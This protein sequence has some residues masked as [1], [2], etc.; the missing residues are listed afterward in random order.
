M[1]ASCGWSGR[2]SC[3]AFLILSLAAAAPATAEWRRLDSPNFVVVGDVGAGTLRD[4]ASRFEGFR[5][6][7]A[8]VLSDRVT[9]T[10]VPTVVVV[11]PSDRGFTPFKPKYQG[12][13]IEVSGL[14]VGGQDVNYIAILTDSGE[15]GMRVVFH[16]YAHLIIS[17]V[18]RNVPSWLNE[19]LAEYYST[20]EP[21]RDG[22]E[23]LL[24]RSIAGHLLR[25]RETRLLPLKELLAV[26]N[27]SPLY[28]EGDRR[29]VFYAQSWALT[30]MLLLGEPPRT[31]QL[32]QYL[33]R[34]GQGVPADDAW[35]Q[36]FGADPI[37]RDLR[38]YVDR[39]AFSAYQYKFPEKVDG[40]DVQPVTLSPADA[41]AFLADFLRQQR[42]PAEAAERLA[43]GLKAGAPTPLGRVT[44]ALLDIDRKEYPSAEKAL[45]ALTGPDDW[46]VAYRAAAGLAELI[47][48]SGEAPKAEQVRAARGLFEAVRAKNREV[49]NG[50][51]RLVELELASNEPAASTT[52]SA[53]ERARLL[54]P[55][56]F[57]YVFLHARVL[58][59][60]G[61]YGAA[62][63]VLAPMMS[64]AYRQEIRDYARKLM[65]YIVQI[66]QA[67]GAAGN[68]DRSAP[69]AAADA[70]GSDG[71]ASA[72]ERG[73]AFQPIFRKLAAD[74]QRLEGVLQRIECTGRVAAFHVQNETGTQ[75]FTSSDLSS[76]EFITYR[77]DLSG[78]VGCGNL[79]EP[80][81]VYVTW[82]PGAAPGDRLVVALE[83]L[84][85]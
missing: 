34:L 63:N 41:E 67:A 12:K 38:R 57:D 74:E 3:T 84:P 76:V 18:A 28:N 62:R 26:S 72:P 56:R 7:L 53:I 66:E 11:F 8:R 45:L 15:E 51:A 2:L 16:E 77:D 33:V 44:A 30:H 78:S 10:A 49:P 71:A 43:R 60:E 36:V 23:A 27:D 37:E 4:I 14:F 61:S 29:S 54:A 42:R 85:K 24:G 25:L 83:F 70:A 46:L 65:G 35:Q 32:A 13:P 22:R 50:I 1:P 6:T 39:H 81:R 75:R 55:G 31:K 68:P 79:K 69:A 52:R 20:Y 47:A 48:D 19:G 82:R 64:P 17:N 73:G 80:M 59:R 5:E 9:A 40:F 21:G 58:A